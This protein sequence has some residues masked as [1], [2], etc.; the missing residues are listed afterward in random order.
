M[1]TA[2]TPPADTEPLETLV[3]QWLAGRAHVRDLRVIVQEHGVVLEGRAATY[4]AKQLAQHA[5]MVVTG[6]QLLA[7][8]IEVRGELS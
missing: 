8:R 6:L 4:Y 7:N 2:N 5:A 1:T 3:R